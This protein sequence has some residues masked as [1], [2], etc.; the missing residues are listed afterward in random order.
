MEKCPAVQCFNSPSAA[1]IQNFPE[2]N[3]LGGCWSSQR[4]RLLD[5]RLRSHVINSPWRS[6]QS[7]SSHRPGWWWQSP[8]PSNRAEKTELAATL[9]H[10]EHTRDKIFHLEQWI[11]EPAHPGRWHCQTAGW[12]HQGQLW[13][14]LL[15][16][17]RPVYQFDQQVAPL[18]G[19]G[20]C[21]ARVSR[22][23]AGWH[24]A[25]HNHVIRLTQ[26]LSVVSPD[27]MFETAVC[28][29]QTRWTAG[30]PADRHSPGWWPRQL[31]CQASSSW[32]GLLQLSPQRAP[33]WWCSRGNSPPVPGY[34]PNFSQRE[35]KSAMMI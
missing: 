33:R 9:K 13:L 19:G 25:G 26:L 2:E 6:L 4:W 16:S 15:P 17:R 1:E 28:S 11:Q 31:P 10:L 35:K 29:P 24:P 5:E 3:H 12:S 14:D 30:S 32:A 27:M 7:R 34:H 23:P 21:L 20:R 18:A 22:T 8:F